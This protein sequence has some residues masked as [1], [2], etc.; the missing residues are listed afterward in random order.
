MASACGDIQNETF[1]DSALLFDEE[2]QGSAVP[3]AVPR[4]C[5]VA[6]THRSGHH[7]QR[8]VEFANPELYPFDRGIPGE[9][10]VEQLFRLGP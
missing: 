3:A 5:A 4:V 6:D 2:R 8:G 7:G 9:Q 1:G 10:Q